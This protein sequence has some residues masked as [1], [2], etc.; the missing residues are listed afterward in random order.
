MVSR[1]IKRGTNKENLWEHGN[2]EQFW[3]EA[4]THPRATRPSETV[5]P[6]RWE[7]KAKTCLQISYKRN[8]PWN[9]KKV[10]VLWN[11]LKNASLTIFQVIYQK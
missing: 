4:W 8:R 6:C 5:V 2:I 1:F 3:K 7:E 10:A 11:N 9:R